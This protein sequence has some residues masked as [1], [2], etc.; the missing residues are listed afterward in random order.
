M[1]N[2]LLLLITLLL[3][4]ISSFAQAPEKFKYQAIITDN[5]DLPVRNKTIG[6]EI[7]ILQSNL[8]GT[9]VYQETFT[10]RTSNV[11]LVNLEIGT[12]MIT[13]GVFSDINWGIKP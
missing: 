11:G 4:N 3:F 2:L 5:K 12:G 8:D 10:T 6:L 1:K 9:I 13:L 7:S